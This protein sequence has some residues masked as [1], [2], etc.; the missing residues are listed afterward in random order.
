MDHN[1]F[2]STVVE[3]AITAALMPFA[4]Y[5]RIAVALSGGVDS[6]V[7]LH[8]LARVQPSQAVIALHV[9]HG[10]SPHANQWQQQCKLLCQSLSIHFKAI[11]VNVNDEG[12]GIEAAAR[13]ARLTAFARAVDKDTLLLTGHHLADQ[14]ET[15]LHRLCRGTGLQGLQ[16]MFSSRPF[17][18]IQGDGAHL[19]SSIL[20]FADQT[21]PRSISKTKQC[22][23]VR[24]LLNVPKQPIVDYA[25]THSLHY[26]N[27]ESNT[28]TRFTRNFLRQVIMGQLKQ[29]W[30]Q[31]EK[32]IARTISH[33]QDSQTLLDSYLHADFMT[34]N[35]LKILFGHSIQIDAL[36]AMPAIKQAHVV[37][38]WLGRIDYPMPSQAQLH[39]V[40]KLLLAKMDACPEVRT[41]YYRFRRFKGRLVCLRVLPDVKTDTILH[42]DVSQLRSSHLG[43]APDSSQ[44]NFNLHNDIKLVLPDGSTLI[45]CGQGIVSP[46]SVLTVR[47]RQGGERC[48]PL[49]RGH[50]QT[51]KKLFQEF[52]VAPWLRDR[53][54]LIYLDDQLLAVGDAWIC[55]HPAIA[56]HS[57]NALRLS[58]HKIVQW[59][60]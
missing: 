26:V 49:G 2:K 28:D 45:W 6:V 44:S 4:H 38:Y 14:A 35:P 36:Q 47:F 55:A 12:R 51:L 22:M 11:K 48:K 52:G 56:H 54:P 58:E 31:V 20:S 42:W 7:L 43:E 23:L 13:E 29:K 24:P 30:P 40:Q 1:V 32:N 17:H 41:H 19:G 50:S 25:K 18:G 33:I 37:R 53:I 3:Q 15:F 8:A 60:D 5:K 39:E 59:H 27:D 21:Q 46:S 10:L 16:G 34:L 9:N 57:A